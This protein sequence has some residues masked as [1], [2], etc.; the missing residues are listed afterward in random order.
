MAFK[1]PYLMPIVKVG[2]FIDSQGPKLNVCAGGY[3]N[4][5][6]TT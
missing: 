5:R 4:N 6:F 3:A 1:W 2:T